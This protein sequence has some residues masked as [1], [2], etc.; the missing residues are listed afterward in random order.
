[1]QV[2]MTLQKSYP[3]PS[4]SST[5]S[6]DRLLSATFFFTTKWSERIQSNKARDLLRYLV[7][8]LYDQGRGNLMNAQIELAQTTL[9]K[10]LRMSRQWIGELT[11]RLEAAGWIEHVSP[12]LADGT[13]GSTIWRIGRQFKRLLVMLAK[14]KR[15]KSRT[16]SDNK[17]TWHF[18]P[19]RREKELLSLPA[20]EKDPPKPEMLAKMPLLKTWLERGKQ[21]LKKEGLNSEETRSVLSDIR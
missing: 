19:L 16:K 5:P 4:L 10:K 17:S 3:T 6:L 20:K 7:C 21:L 1:M 18:S 11:A 9:A 12:K 14:S 2:P 15:G 8:R 13:N